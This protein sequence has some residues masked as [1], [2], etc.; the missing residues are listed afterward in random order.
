MRR[1]CLAVLGAVL[2]AGSA[3]FLDPVV[4]AGRSNGT[5][6][7]F[8][9]SWGEPDLQGIWSG[10]TA[11]PL[12][13]PERWAGRAELTP[14]EKTRLERI[15]HFRAEEFGY[16]LLQ[17]TRPQTLAYALNDSPA[18]Q[19]AWN[20]EWFVDW[21]PTTSDKAPIDRDTILTNVTIFWL[22][23]TAASAARIYLE[24]SGAWGARPAPSPVPTG[25]AN[26][27]GDGAIRGADRR[28]ERSYRH[29]DRDRR[30]RQSP[31]RER[32]T[33]GGRRR[34]AGRG[35]DLRGR[36]RAESR[37]SVADAGRARHGRRFGADPPAEPGDVRVP[38]PGS[39]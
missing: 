28:L 23:G 38:G 1:R 26:F 22:T 6:L 7:V 31:R 34:S 14:A 16:N 8:K 39:P 9:T 30:G 17:A 4:L 24:G 12:Q 10:Q 25:V 20:L 11:T 5:A 21:D 33:P 2:V 37:R 32:A 19:L 13:R 3:V 29:R 35:G 18:G 36:Q 15:E 27:L